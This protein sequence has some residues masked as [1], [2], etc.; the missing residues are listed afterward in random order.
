[1]ADPRPELYIQI[2]PLKNSDHK[3]VTRHKS[4][5][6]QR[7]KVSDNTTLLTITSYIKRLA[8]AESD[9]TSVSLYANYHNEPLQLPLSLSVAEY[10]II[11]NQT[12]QGELRYS[13]AGGVQ[14][15]AVRFQSEGTR[16]R[17]LP[18]VRIAVPRDDGPRYPPPSIGRFGAFQMPGPAIGDASYGSLFHTGFSV[19]S[20][21]FGNFSPSID[22]NTAHQLGEARGSGDD[23]ISLRR[24]LEM[25]I[26]KQ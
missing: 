13:F 2:V 18:E 1:M 3:R 23:P 16:P 7:I 5:P 9:G 25:E 15:S 14:Q 6:L 10:L 22:V 4:N 8:G 21:S 24:N 20:N 19:F 12:D 26:H 17:P 11:T